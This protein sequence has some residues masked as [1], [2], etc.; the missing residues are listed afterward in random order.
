MERETTNLYGKTRVVKR[1]NKRRAQREYE[2]GKTVYLLPCN[3]GL[4]SVW[5]HPCP[6]KQS[7]EQWS[8]DSFNSRVNEFQYYNC[9]YETGYYPHYYVEVD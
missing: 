3:C 6:I 7:E 1:I 2:Q 5:I 8:G 9:N 4:L